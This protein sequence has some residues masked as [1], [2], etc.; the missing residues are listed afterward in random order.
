MPHGAALR[1]P[2]LFARQVLNAGTTQLYHV[3]LSN[4]LYL[5]RLLSLRLLQLKF[6]EQTWCQ[7]ALELGKSAS[8]LV[9][10][11]IYPPLQRRLGSQNWTV[12][13]KEG[14][15]YLQATS[16]PM[17]DMCQNDQKVVYHTVQHSRHQ[18]PLISDL[19]EGYRVETYG[20]GIR[21]AIS[22]MLVLSAIQV[23]W[24]SLVLTGRTRRRRRL[25]FRTGD[26]L[27]NKSWLWTTGLEGHTIRRRPALPIVWASSCPTFHRWA[28]IS[29][30]WRRCRNA[31]SCRWKTWR[32]SLKSIGEDLEQGLLEKM[33]CS[34]VL[35]DF[36]HLKWCGIT[37]KCWIKMLLVTMEKHTLIIVI[38]HPSSMT[39]TQIIQVHKFKRVNSRVISAGPD[40]LLVHSQTPASTSWLTAWKHA[41]QYQATWIPKVPLID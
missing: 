23:K 26:Q 28:K 11:Q 35:P 30:C 15:N 40:K 12:R 22:I 24:K 19:L 32:T 1:A 9:H 5:L 14:P 27:V 17:R 4:N 7:T 25:C 16:V 8:P 39:G 41:N 13:T 36:Q 31:Q 10:L 21:W 34:V 18:N 6:Q 37:K 20:P 3:P 29:H 2:C 38:S 33:S